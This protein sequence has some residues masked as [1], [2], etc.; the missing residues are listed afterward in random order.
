MIRRPQVSF[1]LPSS[2]R[3]TLIQRGVD[4]EWIDVSHEHIP[5]SYHTSPLTSPPFAVGH[6][7]SQGSTL[8]NNPVPGSP[9]LE[10]SDAGL[11]FTGPAKTNTDAL[12]RGRRLK[13]PIPDILFGRAL[14]RAR[15]SKPPPRSTA[16]LY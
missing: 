12:D 1:H 3:R 16:A 4:D 6:P 7:L 8:R 10:L 9:P 15:E 5:E 2:T 11:L 13:G 14:D